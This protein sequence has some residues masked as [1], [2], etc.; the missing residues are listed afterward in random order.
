MLPPA[1]TATVTVVT[2]FMSEVEIS[3]LRFSALTFS[4]PSM[5]FELLDQRPVLLCLRAS[6]H[7]DD[8]LGIQPNGGFVH[9]DD[10]S[11]GKGGFVLF[12]AGHRGCV[13][14]A[15][16]VGSQ[17]QHNLHLMT[18]L[19]TR[20]SRQLVGFVELVLPLQLESF[21]ALLPHPCA[22]LGGRRRLRVF[23]VGVHELHNEAVRLPDAEDQV[24]VHSSVCPQAEGLKL[25]LL[26]SNSPT[27]VPPV[28]EG[29]S[30][31]LSF[32]ALSR[33]SQ[34]PAAW[35]GAPFGI[36]IT[37]VPLVD[38]VPNAVGVNREGNDWRPPQMC[39]PLCPSS[40]STIPRSLPAFP[41]VITV[42]R[43]SAWPARVGIIRSPRALLVKITQPMDCGIASVTT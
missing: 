5:A 14:L 36:P 12:G 8:G 20:C 23:A 28:L 39:I 16:E 38:A 24:L 34:R 17:F 42:S 6:Q 35:H 2:V 43:V 29:L 37:A 31:T 40:A 41:I 21:V 18:E 10:A 3:A 22:Q 19:G 9:A 25:P 33:Y 4:C 32:P 1:V 13:A 7:L 27:S 15:A 11:G 26:L 30:A